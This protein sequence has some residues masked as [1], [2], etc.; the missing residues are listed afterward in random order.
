MK[1]GRRPEGKDIFKGETTV[2]PDWDP[3]FS[4][5]HVLLDRYHQKLIEL[6]SKALA[7]IEN[8]TPCRETLRR[9]LDEFLVYVDA[10]FQ[11][12]EA[13]LRDHDFPHF[14]DHRTV[15]D[16]YFEDLKQL[17]SNM[18]A[19]PIDE[20]SLCQRLATWCRQH[21]LESDMAY[22]QYLQPTA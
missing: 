22:S 18:N 20:V 3:S 5:G 11:V 17:L 9:L 13:I 14:A 12:E 19:A 10:H 4:V 2:N 8:E 1:S 16:Q 7:H 21:I 15:H 6:S